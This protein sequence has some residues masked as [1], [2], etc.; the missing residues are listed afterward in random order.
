MSNVYTPD[1]RH[2][3]VH[4]AAYYL[5]SSLLATTAHAGQCSPGG[6]SYLAGGYPILSALPFI[7]VRHVSV[8]AALRTS[9]I[10]VQNMGNLAAS[11]PKPRGLPIIRELNECEYRFPR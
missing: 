8:T 7:G 3:L 6:S 5:T 9:G 11:G 10:Y 4:A 2:R 1:S